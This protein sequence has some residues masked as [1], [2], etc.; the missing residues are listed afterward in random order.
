[1]GHTL[2][3][4]NHRYK[5]KLQICSPSNCYEPLNGNGQDCVE[6]ASQTDLSDRK[7]NW[8]QMGEYLQSLHFEYL[9]VDVIYSNFSAK[10]DLIQEYIL[11]T[12]EFLLMYQLIW[13]TPQE[14]LKG[15]IIDLKTVNLANLAGEEKSVSSSA[16]FDK[17]FG[18]HC[19]LHKILNEYWMDVRNQKIYLSLIT[20]QLSFL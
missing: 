2:Q 6:W 17:D 20:I 16:L 8:H 13:K 15:L 11:S 3:T 4:T 19:T 1:M 14:R 12:K 18:C 10:V 7:Q 9:I 5:Y